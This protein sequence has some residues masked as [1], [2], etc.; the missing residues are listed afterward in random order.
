MVL[1]VSFVISPVTGLCC[2]RRL[3]DTGVS[4]P[5][6]LTSP[7][8]RLE[9]Q[10]RGV[11]TTRLRRP[12]PAPLVLRRCRVHRIPH[13]TSVTTAKRP[14]CEA[15]W[16]INKTVSTRRRNEIFL[17]RGL[18]SEFAI[19]PDGQISRVDRSG[20]GPCRH[21][22]RKWPPPI[23]M[24]AATSD[25]PLM[26]RDVRFVRICSL[27]PGLGVKLSNA[28]PCRAHCSLRGRGEPS[29]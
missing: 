3:A 26:R 17:R 10:R 21:R 15:G 7:S 11:R 16:R 25:I 23:P 4:G 18:D 29:A 1:T 20:G 27:I 13:P 5:L 6:G 28:R 9:R 24:S 22:Q 14:S 8:A 12:A 2:H 19:P